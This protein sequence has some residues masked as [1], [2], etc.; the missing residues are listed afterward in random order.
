MRIL[1]V[2]VTYIIGLKGIW[3]NSCLSIPGKIGGEYKL[4]KLSITE[5]GE[6]FVLCE[7]EEEA[8]EKVKEEIEKLILLEKVN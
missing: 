7:S 4:S 6:E 8:L 3:K 2:L 1:L 5:D